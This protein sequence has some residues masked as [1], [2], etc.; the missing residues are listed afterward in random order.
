[1]SPVSRGAIAEVCV[2]V[3]VISVVIEKDLTAAPVVNF[4]SIESH[5]HGSWPDSFAMARVFR[6]VDGVGEG[7]IFVS[8]T[9]WLGASGGVVA[10]FSP[11]PVTRIGK[12]GPVMRIDANGEA[13][14]SSSDRGERLIILKIRSRGVSSKFHK[15]WPDFRWFEFWSSDVEPVCTWIPL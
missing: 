1:M 11:L 9:L 4:T 6:A 3:V 14:A 13:I 8:P 5:C 15:A 2:L 7:A 12:N 10:T